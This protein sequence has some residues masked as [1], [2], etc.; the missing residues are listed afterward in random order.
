MDEPFFAAEMPHAGNLNTFLSVLVYAAFATLCVVIT[1]LAR[2]LLASPQ[3]I[4][5]A[6]LALLTG[7][8]FTL[9]GGPLAFYLNTAIYY[10]SALAFGG[11]G[12]FTRQAYLH[13]L[14]FVPLSVV[15][16][17]FTFLQLIPRSGIYLSFAL[18]PI[19]VVADVF[20]QVRAFKVVHGFSTG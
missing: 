4:S 7:S 6:A 18:L 1:S 12:T 17:V 8:C 9:I 3:A 11:K 19:I 14:Y 20:F 15:A 2:D 16:S 13:T 10:L 5:I